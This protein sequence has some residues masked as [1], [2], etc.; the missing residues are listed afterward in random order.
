MKIKLKKEVLDAGGL[1]STG[2]HQGFS[3][4]LWR[5]LNSG[6]TIEIDSIPSRAKYQ[7]EEVAGVGTK[8]NNV[9]NKSKSSLNKG[10]K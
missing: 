8:S 1:C 4:D 3:K 2:S 7:V 5:K 6:N 9:K 10:D